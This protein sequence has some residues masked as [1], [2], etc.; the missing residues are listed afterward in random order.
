V[1]GG[2]QFDRPAVVKAFIGI[3]QNWL[4]FGAG[5][6]LSGSTVTRFRNVEW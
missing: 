2:L 5:M 1:L 6:L 3:I 4:F